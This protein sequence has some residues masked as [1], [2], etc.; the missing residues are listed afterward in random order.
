MPIFSNGSNSSIKKRIFFIHIPRTAGRYVKRIFEYNRFEV[1][2]DDWHDYLDLS[3]GVINRQD[4]YEVPHLWFPWYNKLPVEDAVHFTVVRNPLDR[5]KS[6]A[7]LWKYCN[8][9]EDDYFNSFDL[10]YDD[11]RDVISTATKRLCSWY[12]PQ[13]NFISEKTLIWKY[14][15]GFGKNFKKWIWNNMNIKLDLKNISD[16]EKKDFDKIQDLTFSS[17]VEEM[18][19]QYYNQDYKTFNY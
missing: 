17:H 13:F 4:G 11:L 14:E 18:V 6:A 1:S 12:I 7:K 10:T 19:K 3:T 5:F 15:D 9:L 8:I 16:D 2:W